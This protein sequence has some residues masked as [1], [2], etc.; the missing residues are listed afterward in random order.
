MKDNNNMKSFKFLGF[1]AAM[2][3][4]SALPCVAYAE[5]FSAYCGA[6]TSQLT[7]VKDT[8]VTIS[9][10]DEL[11][12]DQEQEA[13]E[14]VFE[15]ADKVANISVTQSKPQQTV[16]F[17]F[18]KEGTY[19]YKI[20]GYLLFKNNAQDELKGRK[21]VSEGFGKIEIREGAKYAFY[22]ALESPTDKRIRACI[23]ELELADS[24]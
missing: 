15:A 19:K 11:A 7:L 20:F 14:V 3:A 13:F 1:T 5:P 24:E 6:T 4:A 22:S 16:S 8:P 2:L 12:S 23:Q 10:I 21:L 18:P 17:T 9:V